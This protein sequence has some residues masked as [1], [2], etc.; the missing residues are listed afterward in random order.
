[1]DPRIKTS[2]RMDSLPNTVRSTRGDGL[3]G[4][5]DRGGGRRGGR[6]EEMLIDMLDCSGETT[7]NGYGD[8]SKTGV[9]CVCA[10]FYSG[11]FCNQCTVASQQFPSCFRMEGGEEKRREEGE[12][13]RE[14][15]RGIVQAWH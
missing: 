14:E 7:C 2:T 3:G 9:P 5:E 1:M 13:E 6:R 11:P 4:R 12:R 10:M 15:G 8:C